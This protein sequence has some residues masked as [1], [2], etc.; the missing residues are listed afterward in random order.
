MLCENITY[1]DYWGYMLHPRKCLTC[2]TLAQVQ[3]SG[4]RDELVV[5]HPIRENPTILMM[6]ASI[7][8]GPE[9]LRLF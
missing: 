3:L 8:P 6:P 2:L 7:M 5:G 1:L 4:T 9:L